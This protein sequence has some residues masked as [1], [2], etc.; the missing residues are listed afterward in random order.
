[1]RLCRQPCPRRVGRVSALV[2]GIDNRDVG[3]S[4]KVPGACRFGRTAALAQPPAG[5]PMTNQRMTTN[6]KPR[7][8]VAL[9]EWRETDLNRRHPHFQCVQDLGSYGATNGLGIASEVL[10]RLRPA[11]YPDETR[12][13]GHALGH[14][15]APDLCTDPDPELVADA[16]STLAEPISSPSSTTGAVS[17]APRPARTSSDLRECL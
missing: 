13:S 15:L 17:V 12:S 3:R 6:D 14:A 5:D 1:M 9:C 11:Q 16:W 2:K 10:P 8:G 4:E 7:A